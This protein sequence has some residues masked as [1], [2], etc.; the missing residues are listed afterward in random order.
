MNIRFTQGKMPPRNFML[1]VAEANPQR[2]KKWE[3]WEETWKRYDANPNTLPSDYPLWRL[4]YH[5]HY[6]PEAAVEY[7]KKNIAL[8]EDIKQNGFNYTGFIIRAYGPP[9]N[10]IRTGHNIISI[11]RHLHPDATIEVSGYAKP[12]PRR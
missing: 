6:N 12:P 4:H 3:H 1:P 8:Y 9:W 10:Y 11:L 2:G 5:R 7:V